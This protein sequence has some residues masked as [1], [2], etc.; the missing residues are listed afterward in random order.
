MD[1]IDFL[2]RNI[3]DIYGNY[4]TTWE[5]VSIEEFDN[6]FYDE[7][8]NL[9]DD[10]QYIILNNEKIFNEAIFEELYILACTLGGDKEISL[11]RLVSFLVSKCYV[12]NYDNKKLI[13]FINQSSLDKLVNLFIDNYDF[14]M[15]L[16][17][18][19]FFTLVDSKK[20]KEVR[21]KILDSNDKGRLLILE[22]KA[23]NDKIVTINSILRDII[24]NLFNFYIRNG[25][26]KEEALNNTWAY[27][28]D[29]FDP[30]GEL[31][32]MGYD[33]D[34][35]KGLQYLALV[36]MYCDLY[37]DICNEAIINNEEELNRKIKVLVSIGVH[38]N[39]ISIPRDKM[40]RN[41][42]L[43]YFLL[44]KE[45]KDKRKYNREHSHIEERIKVLKKVNPIYFL[46]ELT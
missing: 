25:C 21:T 43:E 28:I 42:M 32:K 31:D 2:N 16:I 39:M 24:A 3:I 1:I 15:R 6:S 10:I 14:G 8:D 38:L 9:I 45:E 20:Y 30:L 40:L 11:D 5:N 46:D 7:D 17:R 12:Y 19:Y 13:Q 29:N 4:L 44:L 34:T 18:D 37:E 36:I 33:F 41:G 23:I 27:F 35:K 26:N 22:N